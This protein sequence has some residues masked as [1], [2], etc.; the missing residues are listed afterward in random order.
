MQNAARKTLFHLHE[1]FSGVFIGQKGVERRVGIG[2]HIALV[3]GDQN[4]TETTGFPEELQAT[5]FTSGPASVR[6]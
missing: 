1:A 4:L 5:R 2:V 3:F 6:R